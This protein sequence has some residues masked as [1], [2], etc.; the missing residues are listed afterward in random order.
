MP[1]VSKAQAK[2]MY[3]NKPAMAAEWSSKT[4]NIKALP[5]HV[6]KKK[7]KTKIKVSAMDAMRK[8]LKVTSKTPGALISAMNKKKSVVAKKKKK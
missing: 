7:M 5:N 1:F 4:Q 8:K 6:K 3:A 2:W